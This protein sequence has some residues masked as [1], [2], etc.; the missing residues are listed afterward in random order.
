VWLVGGLLTLAVIGAIYQAIATHIDERTYLPPGEMVD[1]NGHLMHINCMGE[2]G[3]TVILEAA[4]LGM[5]AHWVRVQQQLAKTTRVCAYDR[6]G[7][8]WGETGPEP[9]DA[10]QISSE[11]HTL[12]K[13]ADTEGP[14]VMV[15][16]SYGGL[17]ARVYAARYPN[18]VAGVA[19]VD[20]SHPEQFTRSPQGRAMYEQTRRMGVVIPW[21]ARL[22]VIRLTNFYPAHPD[23]PAQQREQIEAF[24]SSTQQWVTTVEE[25]SATPQTNDQVR[26]MG[27]LGDKPLAVIS[28]GEQSSSWLEMQEELAA[29]SSDSI[30]RVVE[31]A[32]HES[33]LY[34][35]GDSQVSSAAIEQVVEAVRTDQPLTR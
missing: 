6:A 4:N 22:G 3:P 13:G 7:M 12:L 31:G 24:N 23:L 30:H 5:S 32:T 20:S 11:L 10:R 15:G 26:S 8:G 28:A 18:Q 19:L 29:L 34:D 17:Y 25:F 33:L 9:R 16:H 21:L 14:C 2:G 1:V 27:S 35:K